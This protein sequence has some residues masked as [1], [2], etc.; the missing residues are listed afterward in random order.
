LPGLTICIG[1]ISTE[2]KIGV[3]ILIRSLASF[4]P[5]SNVGALISIGFTSDD[6]SGGFSTQLATVT[7]TVM[8]AV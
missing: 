3:D 4:C 7:V 1:N 6:H 8:S 5:V 2:R